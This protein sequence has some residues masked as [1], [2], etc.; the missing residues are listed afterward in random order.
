MMQKVIYQYAT[1]DLTISGY[2]PNSTISWCK[3]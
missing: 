1:I 2:S 3:Y